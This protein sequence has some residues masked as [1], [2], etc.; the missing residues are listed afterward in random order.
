VASHTTAK[1]C[2]SHNGKS[3]ENK[4]EQEERS[5][6]QETTSLQ[7]ELSSA[8]WSCPFFNPGAAICQAAITPRT[9]FRDSQ[10]S[11]CGSE[12]YEDCTTFLVGLLARPPARAR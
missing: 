6:N 3:G 11:A 2:A 9:P 10:S 7:V 4:N 5:V 1:L 8:G 12:A